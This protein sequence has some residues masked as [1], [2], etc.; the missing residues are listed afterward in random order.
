MPQSSHSHVTLQS[1]RFGGS[2]RR[3]R[4]GI[5]AATWLFFITLLAWNLPAADAAATEKAATTTNR[6]L[7]VAVPGVRDY[8]EYGGH[9][10]LVFD[11]DHGHRFVRRIPARGLGTN[12]QPLNVKGV[13][14]SAAT[15][16][17]YVSTLQFL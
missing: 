12:G 7:Y 9:G 5:V 6:F 8:L 4:S 2:H 15:G 14:A 3:R 13:A 10:V 16:R 11:I 1:F 17:L